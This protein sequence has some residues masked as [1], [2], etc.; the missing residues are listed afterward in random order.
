M[1]RRGFVA[2]LAG[3]V[4]ARAASLTLPPAIQRYPDAATEFP[5]FR[6]TDPTVSSY[7]PVGASH[8]ISRRGDFLL[9]A[10]DAAGGV[11][12]FR[13]DT[14]KGE[15]RQLTEAASL[16]PG[17]LTLLPDARGF[18]YVDEDRLAASPLSAGRRRTVY[19][20]PAGFEHV[21]GLAVS[22]DALYCALVVRRGAAHR[23]LLVDLRTGQA[24]TLAEADEPMH[25]P[26]PRPRRASVLYLRAGGV[27]LAN[28]DGK[29]NYRLR[30]AEGRVEQ[31]MWSPD[32]RAVLYLHVPAA[33]GRL[34]SIREFVPDTNEDRAIADTTQFVR[35]TA[36]ADASV[37]AG[38][39][40]SKATP[41]IFLLVRAVG[42][43]LTLCEHRAS[44]PAMAVPWFAP[45]SQQIYF[46]SD[47]HGKPAIYRLDVEK[48]VAETAAPAR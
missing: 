47:L 45:N 15:A 14:K 28:Y 23:L 2:S 25:A 27:W 3:G 37:F 10:T 31:A 39:S 5:V 30:L 34:N 26:L 20:L 41:Y 1:T 17:A 43:E 35:F 32:G 13:L 46:T 36:N 48:L 44:D 33:G 16:S 18:L 8:V 40:G 29:Q 7:L 11:Q 12:A 24:A 38:A 21:P 19:A 9:Y 6:L 4:L 22:I 42:R